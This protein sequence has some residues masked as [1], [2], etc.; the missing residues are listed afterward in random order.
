MTDSTDPLIHII[1]QFK[2]LSK[3]LESGGQYSKNCGRLGFTDENCIGDYQDGKLIK[4]NK[5]HAGNNKFP[6]NFLVNNESP[7]FKVVPAGLVIAKT[8]LQYL[9][10]WNT[11]F[12]TIDGIIAENQQSGGG[13]GRWP[14]SVT[15]GQQPPQ[16][17]PSGFNNILNNAT[18]FAKSATDS[19]SNLV[20]SGKKKNVFIS[21]HQHLLQN[22]FFKF[23]KLEDKDLNKTDSCGKSMKQYGFRN[24]T[25]IKISKEGDKEITITVIHSENTGRD[26][27]KYKYIDA[28]KDLIPILE[29]EKISTKDG[30]DIPSYPISGENFP[31]G[32]D[33]Y[34]IRHGEAVHNLKDVNEVKQEKLIC[35][36]DEA[37][38]IAITE[39]NKEMLNKMKALG[40]KVYPN[41]IQ[42]NALLTTQG[43]EQSNNLYKKTLK[44]II[45]SGNQNIY[46]SSPMDR[47]IETLIFATSLNG[48]GFTFLKKQFMEMYKVRFNQTHAALSKLEANSL[49]SNPS[50]TS[51]GSTWSSVSSRDST[52]STDSTR[53]TIDL[54]PN[55]KNQVDTTEVPPPKTPADTP[56]NQSIGNRLRSWWF[57]GGKRKSRRKVNKKSKKR[58]SV[59]ARKTKKR[60]RN[61]K[62][63][64][65]KGCSRK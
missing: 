13:G 16:P 60:S 5:Y 21:C 45:N 27:F 15:K 10:N 62:K 58:K 57:K 1:P 8:N 63:R 9:Q 12:Q 30:K 23:K 52:D 48:Q 22:M 25:C 65:Q 53:P 28:N 38:Q 51:R 41:K 6:N 31:N 2:E 49:G 40:N 18:E 56:P 26:K 14:W 64:Y 61:T 19:F 11:L 35:N 3:N 44:P 33:I 7:N 29:I 34:M 36:P 32:C 50:D 20:R 17:D 59:K 4:R 37:S 54:S 47:T 43:I 46:I 39:G 42:L 55:F 24:C